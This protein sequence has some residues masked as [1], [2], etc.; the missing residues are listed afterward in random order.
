K[1]RVPTSTFAALRGKLQSGIAELVWS[2][3]VAG[4]QENVLMY[5]RPMEAAS[6]Q[7]TIVSPLPQRARWL[8][9]HTPLDFSLYDV[10]RDLPA[11]TAELK[12]DLPDV[13]QVSD[14][15]VFGY[16]EPRRGWRSTAFPRASPK[17]RSSV[18]RGCGERSRSCFC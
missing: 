7:S 15:I 2:A 16:V 11:V 1:K 4:R 3:S 17:R 14:F 12:C 13:E 6:I 5:E 18:P 10:P 8:I 9:G